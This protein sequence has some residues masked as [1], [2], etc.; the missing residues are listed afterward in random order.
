[1]VRMKVICGIEIKN[2]TEPLGQYWGSI[3]R[4]QNSLSVKDSSLDFMIHA[5]SIEVHAHVLIRC[6]KYKDLRNRM[7]A[8]L[9][10][11]QSLRSIL[12]TPRLSTKVI[13]YIEQT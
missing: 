9:S 5:V 8:N 3:N 1:M 10:G 12:S 7:F 2:E 11:Q 4:Q 13:E 6:S